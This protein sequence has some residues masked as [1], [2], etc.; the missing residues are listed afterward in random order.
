MF[1]E[2]LAVI[3]ETSQLLG[4]NVLEGVRQRHFT[5]AMMMAVRLAVRGNVDQLLPLAAVIKGAQ[6]PIGESFAAG[7]QFFKRDRLRDRG[8]V[9]KDG[10]A[11]S[12]RQLHQI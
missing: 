4:L 10:D 9:E 3:A 1:L 2:I 11:L 7:Q 12:P 8:I 6:Q 5:M